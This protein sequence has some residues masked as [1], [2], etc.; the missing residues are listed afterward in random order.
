MARLQFT[1]AMALFGSK[2]RPERSVSIQRDRRD[3]TVE[4]TMKLTITITD[5]EE[6]AKRATTRAARD[7]NDQFRARAK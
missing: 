7:Y 1:D 6:N 5:A 2:R 3:S 4:R